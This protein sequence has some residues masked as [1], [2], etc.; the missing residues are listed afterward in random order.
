MDIP[1]WVASS[2]IL[3]T[4]V[5]SFRSSIPWR[6]SVCCIC[7][8]VAFLC[9]MVISTT[10]LTGWKD[11]S[12]FSVSLIIYIVSF[13]IVCNFVVVG[14]RVCLCTS[15]VVVGT[16]CIISRLVFLS[17]ELTALILIVTWFLQWWHVGLGLLEFCCGACCVT[18]FTGISCGASKPFNSNSLSRCDTMCSYVPFSKCAWLIDF[19]RWGGTLA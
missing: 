2:I 16:I 10:C 17:F 5:L 7:S 11:R 6:R 8:K 13:G 14:V 12:R 15:I 18:V 3:L 19:F 1:V 4:F 9:G